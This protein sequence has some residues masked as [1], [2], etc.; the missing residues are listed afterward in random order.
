MH[1][2][3]GDKAGYHKYFYVFI[4][5]ESFIINILKPQLGSHTWKLVSP[6][7]QRKTQLRL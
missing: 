1:S 5:Y 7:L 3:Y 2:G 4:P 6:F